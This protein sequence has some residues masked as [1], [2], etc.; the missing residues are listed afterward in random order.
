[1]VEQGDRGGATQDIPVDLSIETVARVISFILSG[2]IHSQWLYAYTFSLSLNSVYSNL[3]GY[4]TTT[5]K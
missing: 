4:T 2:N 1:M 5:R 3:P